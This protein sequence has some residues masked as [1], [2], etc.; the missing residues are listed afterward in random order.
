MACEKR[1]KYVFPFCLYFTFPCFCEKHVKEVLVSA[2][3]LLSQFLEKGVKFGRLG[4]KQ[5]ERQRATIFC[6]KNGMIKACCLRVMAV[7]MRIYDLSVNGWTSCRWNGPSSWCLVIIITSGKYFAFGVYC[8]DDIT[9]QQHQQQ[10]L[11]KVFLRVPRTINNSF[12]YLARIDLLFGKQ[13]W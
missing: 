10:R 9:R 12:F 7:C 8:L 4:K 6:E 1:E 2:G 13:M 5:K 11:N 3:W